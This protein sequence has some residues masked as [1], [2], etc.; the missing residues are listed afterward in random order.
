[1][2][3][4]TINDVNSALQKWDRI[5]DL[6]GF[7]YDSENQRYTYQNIKESYQAGL[8]E[9]LTGF[10]LDNPAIRSS[11][12][13]ELL[14]H[15]VSLRSRI[16][17]DQERSGSNLLGW[18]SRVDVSTTFFINTES[19]AVNVLALG[20]GAVDVFEA[21]KTPLQMSSSSYFI[22]PHNVLSAV[23][24]VSSPGYMTYGPDHNYPVGTYLVDF[25]LRAPSPTG[26]MATI[27]IIDSQN[28]QILA[29]RDVLGSSMTAGNDW[30]RVTLPI[31]VTNSI[32]SLEFRIYWYGTANMDIAAIRVRNP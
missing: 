32:N 6:S 20:A 28:N 7:A 13:Q 19:T 10:L 15:W 26:T 9:I 16:L 21:G 5:L 8:F 1:L 22:R 3:D 31:S 12:Q 2:Y 27:D 11:K 4:L 25:L 24:G 14:T 29:A 30:T 18:R 17:S 23:Q